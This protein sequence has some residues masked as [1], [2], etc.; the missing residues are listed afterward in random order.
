MTVHS[1]LKLL[2]SGMTLEEVLA[3][4]AYLERAGG[5]PGLV[6]VMLRSMYSDHHGVGARCTRRLDARAASSNTT[7]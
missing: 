5:V 7:Q 6:S 2:A 3:Y 4:Y 1:I